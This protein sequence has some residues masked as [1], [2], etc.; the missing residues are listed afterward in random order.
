MKII[1][2][3]YNLGN[4]LNK[5]IVLISDIHYYSKKDIKRLN[6]V[7]DNIKRIKPDYICISGDNFDKAEVF[8]FDLLI[9]WLK[10]LADV[11]KV[12]MTLGNHDFYENKERNIYKLNTK[13]INKIKKIEN[14]YFLDNQNKVL[15]NINFIGLVLPINHYQFDNESEKEFEK[16]VQ[17]V[18]PI[19][20]YYN[21]LLCHSPINISKEKFLNRINVDLVLC[22]HMHGGVVPRF[23]RFLFGTKGLISPQKKLFPKNVYG[24]IKVGNKN[25]IITSGIKVLSESHFPLLTNVFSS[26]IVEI[27]F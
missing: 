10:K 22:G 17:K 24:N 15:D 23:L 9:V 27:S 6:N 8:D 25:V 4:E 2:K 14:L 20:K 16:Y 11:T 21:V 3:K 19:N 18:K 7:L 12:I 26:E 1:N 5:K 13:Y